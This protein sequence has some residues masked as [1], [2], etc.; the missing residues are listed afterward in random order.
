MSSLPVATQLATSDAAAIEFMMRRAESPR[1][2][3]GQE[4]RQY[5]ANNIQICI[6][7]D[8]GYC[9]LSIEKSISGS[10]IDQ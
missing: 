8:P 6:A 1:N 9:R 4:Q 5:D 2:P 7:R 10:V 3:A